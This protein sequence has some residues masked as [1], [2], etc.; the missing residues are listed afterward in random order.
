[1]AKHHHYLHGN[2][3]RKRKGVPDAGILAQTKLSPHPLQHFKPQNF[4]LQIKKMVAAECKAAEAANENVLILMLGHGESR[5]RG[6]MIGSG[7]RGTFK[8]AEFKKATK[9][10][11]VG[12]TMI[13]TACYSGG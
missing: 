4:K 11:K 6:I 5:N 9:S 10:F 12:I 13:S 8:I 2:P 3:Y 7:D 1:M